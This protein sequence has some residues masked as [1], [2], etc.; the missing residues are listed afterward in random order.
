MEQFFLFL[1]IWA[2]G[3]IITANFFVVFD[4][5]L[6]KYSQNSSRLFL[7]CMLWPVTWS[8]ILYYWIRVKLGYK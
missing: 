1:A 2:L 6:S 5:K 7:S 8:L 4:R 3:V